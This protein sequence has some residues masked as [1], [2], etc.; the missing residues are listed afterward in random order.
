MTDPTY[1]PAERRP[2]RTRDLAVSKR[3]AD[4]LAARG[5]SANAISTAGML[6]AIAGAVALAATSL[7]SPWTRLLWLV[8][9]A[10][11]QLRLLA[12]M[13][14]GMVAIESGRASPVGELFN[15]VPDRIS[16]AAM[17][18]GLGY[19]A[20]GNPALGYLAALAAVFTAYVRAMA[21]VA[22]APQDFGG[23]MAKPQRMFVV[24]LVSLYNALAPSAWQPGWGLAAIALAIIA[25]GGLLTACLRLHRAAA[26]LRQARQ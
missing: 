24:T 16:D 10:G 6:A 23:P 26:Y 22:G 4:W 25:A 17:F 8:G 7:E 9:A 14:D 18:I 1:Q 13:L 12:N 5:V 3:A 15:E 2:I 21:K 19:A 11:A 20:G